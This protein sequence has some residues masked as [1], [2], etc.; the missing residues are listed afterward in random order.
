M[1]RQGMVEQ[2]SVGQYLAIP[3]S[4]FRGGHSKNDVLLE[5]CLGLPNLFPVPGSDEERRLAIASWLT[6]PQH[7]FW[8]VWCGGSL[9]G[10]M[11]LTRITIGLD[12]LAHLAFWDKRLVGRKTLIRTMIAWS[13]TNLQL[14]RLSV[15][16][17]EDLQPLIRFC[18]VKLGFRYEGQ[19][20][21]SQHPEVQLL[22][23]R[24]I[25]GPDQWVAKFGARRERAH[26]NGEGWK[27]LVCLRLLKD[28][29]N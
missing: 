13:F 22:H 16:I 14:Q 11:G 20:L 23:D 5:G 26:W 4:P 21:A 24:R 28:E 3:F 1:P 6:N 17:P 9:I 29:L 2:V 19:F 7:L 27:D 15:E 18:R 25:N 8:E 12:A 10:I